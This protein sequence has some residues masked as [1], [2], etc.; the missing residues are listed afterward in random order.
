MIEMLIDAKA[1]VE[2]RTNRGD[3][4]LHCAAQRGFVKIVDRLIKANANVNAVNE[5]QGSSL[6]LAS[7]NGHAEV[8]KVLLEAGADVDS[9]ISDGWTPLSAA[10]SAGHAEA[11]R[12]LL[13]A[14]PDLSVKSNSGWNALL[15]ASP[16]YPVVV[17]QL[18][19]QGADV[20]VTLMDGCGPLQ[21]ASE[22]GCLDVV[23]KLLEYKVDVNAKDKAGRTALHWAAMQGHNEVAK[24]LLTVMAGK[25][26][27]RKE[28]GIENS[29][30]FVPVDGDEVS[31]STTPLLMDAKDMNGKTS[32]FYAVSAGHLKVI[33]ALLDAGADCR[34]QNDLGATALHVA[35]TAGGGQIEV[36]KLL[37]E[38]KPELLGV[39]D[40]H[41]NLPID[42]AASSGNNAVVEI[43]DAVRSVVS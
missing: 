31:Q 25:T 19:A 29:P 4:P 11:V 26:E 16:L 39:Q 30:S 1:D 2:A 34:N 43:L 12:A 10:A 42:E 5:Y 17:E 24:R 7:G 38:R 41:G 27:H 21:L 37:L 3:S 23:N 35:A 13:A 32:M 20:E 33:E 15:A 8:I 28:S 18:L 9:K 22:F 36:L 40:M 14:K 6:Y